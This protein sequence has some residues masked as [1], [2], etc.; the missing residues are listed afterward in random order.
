MVRR[1]MD[2]P[3]RTCRSRSSTR[4]VDPQA[5]SN[6]HLA[7]TPPSARKLKERL[8]GSLAEEPM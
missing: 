7:C 3:R 8:Q 6:T 1:D 4:T 2:E 5:S